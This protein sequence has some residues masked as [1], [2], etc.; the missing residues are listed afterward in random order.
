VED[1]AKFDEEDDVDE[2]ADVDED[3]KEDAFLRQ[4]LFVL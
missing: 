1:A 2:E 3:A 4:L